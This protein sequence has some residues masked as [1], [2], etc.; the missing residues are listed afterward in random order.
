MQRQTLQARSDAGPCV[1]VVGLGQAA[2]A[3]CQACK[4]PFVATGQG[5]QQVKHVGRGRDD[6]Q[7]LHLV[8]NGQAFPL[9]VEVVPTHRQHLAGSCAGQ[10]HDLK[11][12]G[13]GGV[14][15]LANV[16]EPRGQLFALQHV[17]LR[18]RLAQRFARLAG[19]AGVLVGQHRCVGGVFAAPGKEHRQ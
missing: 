18:G 17:R 9:R 19:L 13:D 8:A 5:G 14:L 4:H 6:A 7:A 10:Q 16:R 3:A 15:N 11:H 12:G 2:A 1:R